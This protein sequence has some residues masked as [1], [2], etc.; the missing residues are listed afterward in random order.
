M[1][2][3]TVYDVYVTQQQILENKNKEL[4]KTQQEIASNNVT[5]S[6]N[7]KEQHSTFKASSP[8][9]NQKGN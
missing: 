5:E 2:V 9:P 6:E 1:T 7:Q 3:A 8:A 4:H